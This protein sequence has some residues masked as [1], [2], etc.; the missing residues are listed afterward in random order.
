MS[1]IKLLSK[2][3]D[4]SNLTYYFKNKSIRL[5]NFIG[6]KVSLHLYRDIFDGNIELAKAEKDEKQFKLDLNEIAKGNP[7][8]NSE[9]QIKTTK[10]IKSPYESREKVFK[11]YNDYVKIRS[12]AM[13]KAKY[14]EGLK[15]L[16][17][18]QMLHRLPI[19]LAQVKAGKN[20]VNLSYE[21]R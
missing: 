7:K 12:E 16:T 14:G 17:S 18:K 9:D 3:I 4:L 19:V 11:L 2:Q 1:K 21:I 8:K 6:F 5:I 15:I 10:S 13:Y 20:S